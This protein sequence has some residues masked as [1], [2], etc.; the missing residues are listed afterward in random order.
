MFLGGRKSLLTI[1]VFISMSVLMSCS[2]NRILLRDDPK[3]TE[4]E[5]IKSQM[6]K[7]DAVEAIKSS[8]E[9]YYKPKQLAVTDTEYAFTMGTNM[10]ISGGVQPDGSIA[11]IRIRGND[12]VF[13]VQFKDVIEIRTMRWGAVDDAIAFWDQKR[14]AIIMTLNDPETTNANKKYAQLIC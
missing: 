3:L 14:Y 7:Q 2:Q 5:V 6:T 13:R 4:I 1:C 10:T 12:V 11:E 8:I 9:K